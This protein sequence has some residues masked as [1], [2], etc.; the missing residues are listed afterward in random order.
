MVRTLIELKFWCKCNGLFLQL[1]LTRNIMLKVHNLG[2]V[3]E[4]GQFVDAVSRERITILEQVISLLNFNLFMI[5]HLQI[6]SLI[7][8]IS[9]VYK[10]NQPYS[11]RNR[12]YKFKIS[13][14][15]ETR[16]KFLKQTFIGVKCLINVYNPALF[17]WSVFPFYINISV[18][19]W[20]LISGYNN[21]NKVF[22]H[23]M[24]HH[25]NISSLI[26]IIPFL[27]FRET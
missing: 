18:I 23:N 26:F 15:I 20:K 24:I 5:L 6:C 9:L 17:L 2:W 4:L 3:W 22:F 19:I 11:F 25:S 12:T 27:I 8:H 7:F 10:Y 14:V 13:S 1:F 21:L 16:V